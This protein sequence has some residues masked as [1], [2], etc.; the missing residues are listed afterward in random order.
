MSD[1]RFERLSGSGRMLPA[2]YIACGVVTLA[3][4][5]NV[6]GTLS[7][8]LFI[9]AGTLANVWPKRVET[10]GSR[11]RIQRPRSKSRSRDQLRH[12]KATA[13]ARNGYTA[14]THDPTKLGDS[15]IVGD[16]ADP[17]AA[18]CFKDGDPVP[19]RV[20]SRFSPFDQLS[21]SLRGMVADRLSVSAKPA[22]T[23]LIERGSQ[24]DLSIYLIQG[25]L[26]LEAADGKQ[27]TVKGG[28]PRARSPLCQLRPHVYSVTSVT[29]VVVVM[30]SQ[31]LVSDIMQSIAR[32][33][34]D[35][36]IWVH[37]RASDTDTSGYRARQNTAS[38]H[39][40]YSF[41]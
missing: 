20:L 24:D 3:F 40:G 31:T 36:G 6:Y 25:T 15:T 12:R 17:G 32:H 26:L 7:G 34:P 10:G 5:P 38:H 21:E 22:G 18:D 30:L 27:V 8:V 37:E 4:T 33:K 41:R 13:S 29:N 16:N 39:S 9:G 28:T 23:S 2:L 14:G 1:G 35:S 19:C 11:Q